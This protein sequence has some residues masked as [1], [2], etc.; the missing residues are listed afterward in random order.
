M[1]VDPLTGRGEGW[2]MGWRKDGERM[3]GRGGQKEGWSEN[4]VEGE[5]GMEGKWGGR[6]E[7][8]EM[9]EGGAR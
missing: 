4:G 3:G 8:R 2:R 1:V 7:V 6:R 9:V 5:R